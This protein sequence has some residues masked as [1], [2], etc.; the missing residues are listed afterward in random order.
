MTRLDAET[1]SVPP[2]HKRVKRD[3]HGWVVLDKPVGMSSTHAVSVVKRLFQ[4]KRAGHAGT[5]DP[6]ASGLLP[7]A[8]GEATK[9]VAFVMEGRK[10]YRF[11]VRW[12]EERDTD[13]AEGRITESSDERPTAAAIGTLLARFTGQITQVPP[14]FSAVK[15]AGER[16]YD[17][18][19]DGEVV[20]IAPRPVEIHRLE[21]IETPDPDHAVLVA[22]CGKGTYVRALARDLGRALK[23]LGHVAALRRTAV[24]PFGE[25]VASSLDALQRICSGRDDVPERTGLLPVEAG[26]AALPAL[27]VST[28]DAGRLARGQAVL[29][30]GRDAPVIGGWVAVFSQGALIALAEVE[31]GEVRPRRIFNLPR[32]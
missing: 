5:L 19:R 12:G 24:G 10:V 18:A 3:V 26:V 22:E 32:G 1:P 23:C 28:G 9:T 7:I 29:L 2:K 6:L 27:R 30:R 25:D 20:D 15:I 14:R 4:A 31:K 11:T 8:L 17:L 13:D 21:L 16:A